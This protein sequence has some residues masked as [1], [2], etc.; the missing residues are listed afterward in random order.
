[1]CIEAVAGDRDG[2]VA[3]EL[4]A[5]ILAACWAVWVV[6]EGKCSA[7]PKEIDYSKVSS[8]S[9]SIVAMIF[10]LFCS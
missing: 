7:I 1:M 2:S 10:V 8:F 6:L 5:V 3:A 9:L 4:A